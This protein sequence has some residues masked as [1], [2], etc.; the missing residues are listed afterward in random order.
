VL[1]VSPAPEGSKVIEIPIRPDGEFGAPWPDGFFP[2]RA[3]EL[4]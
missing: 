3:K 2:D 1:Y 4:F